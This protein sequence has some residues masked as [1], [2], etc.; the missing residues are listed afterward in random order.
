[1]SQ[2]HSPQA[3]DYPEILA[4]EDNAPVGVAEHLISVIIPN[5]NGGAT[6][7]RCLD[8]VFASWYKRF[9]VIVVDDCSSDA[10]VDVVREFPCRL[11]QLDRRSGAARARN[12]GARNSRGDIL[13]FLDADCVMLENTLKMVDKAVAGLDGEYAVIGGTYTRK[14]YDDSF[15]SSFQSVFVN[16][17]EMKRGERPDYIATH[18]LAIERRYFLESAGFREDFLPILE[19]V[20][21]SHRLRASGGRLVM[22]PDVLVRHIFGF[23]FTGS[24][25]NARRKSMYWAMYSM[26]NGDLFADSGTASLALK[27][28]GVTLFIGIFSVALALLLGTPAVALLGLVSLAANLFINRGLLA[29]FYETYG[30]LFSVGA[31]L[32]YILIYPLPIWAGVIAGIYRHLASGAGRRPSG[33]KQK[34]SAGTLRVT[35]KEPC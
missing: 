25:R 33:G 3:L 12:T 34:F 21:F 7:R 4:A 19:D 22:S 15:Y 1:M 30:A 11:I 20:E 32:Y 2:E 24:L 9:E 31:A 8:A 5:Y 27:V 17:F 10:S 18:A 23:S 26:G 16:Y 14:P 13:F 6:I 35:P 29:A 28:N